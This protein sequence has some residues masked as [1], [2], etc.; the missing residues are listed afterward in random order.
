MRIFLGIKI[1]EKTKLEIQKAIKPLQ[2][3][4]PTS[5][6]VPT[7][8]YHVTVCFLGEVL[9]YKKMIPKIE[10]VL[11]DLPPF[12]LELMNGGVFQRDTL[13][14]FVQLY[15]Q[16]E[17]EKKV[18]QLNVT[19]LRRSLEFEYVPHITIARTR[20]PSKQQYTHLKKKVESLDFDHSFKVEEITLYKS[21]QQRGGIPRY[22]VLH[23]FT[24]QE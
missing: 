6:W 8:N 18:E 5:L 21:E 7:G 11:Y 19:L 9:D 10:T 15:R 14:L 4:Y 3:D 1:P 17:L 16:K 2:K 22:E 24:L 13:T 12:H 23:E 20:N